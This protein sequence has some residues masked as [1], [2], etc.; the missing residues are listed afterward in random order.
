MFDFPAFRVEFHLNCGPMLSDLISFLSIWA[1]P[2]IW[3]WS[4]SFSIDVPTNFSMD[5][6]PPLLDL[7]ARECW[8]TEI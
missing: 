4:G 6:P 8:A 5:V 2:A 7:D 3:M 1:G